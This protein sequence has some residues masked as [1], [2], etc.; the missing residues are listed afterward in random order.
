MLD[1]NLLGASGR[2]EVFVLRSTFRGFEVSICLSLVGTKVWWLKP[3]IYFL[4]LF[5]L[6]VHF[7]V[8]CRLYKAPILAFLEIIL[9]KQSS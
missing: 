5:G 9:Q 2:I 7:G 1:L 8:E 3:A 4:L 6:W